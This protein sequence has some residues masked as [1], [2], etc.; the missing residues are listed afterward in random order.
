MPKQKNVKDIDSLNG[1]KQSWTSGIQNVNV[2]S[3][4]FKNRKHYNAKGTN[5]STISLGPGTSV[6]QR[7]SITDPQTQTLRK[8]DLVSFITL[9]K[10]IRNSF[11]KKNIDDISKHMAG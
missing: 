7:E 11:K 4:V 6:G 8:K 5:R 2:K 1:E 3:T 10:K 9:K